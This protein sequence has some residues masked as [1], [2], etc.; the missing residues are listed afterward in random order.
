[1]SNI[2]RESYR[3]KDG[4]IRER[5]RVRVQRKNLRLDR[6]FPTK[7]EAMD[8]ARAASTPQGAAFLLPL[9]PQAL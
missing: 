8:A 9:S 7:K 6:C 5:W 1:M 3:T 2:K 4:E